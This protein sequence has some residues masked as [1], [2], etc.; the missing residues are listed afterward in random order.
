V[1]IDDLKSGK[2]SL[3]SRR[4]ALV[5]LVSYI[6]GIFLSLV[7]GI[8]YLTPF[9]LSITLLLITFY[10]YTKGNSQFAGWSA[11]ILMACIGWFN[12]GL[13]RG[14][15]PPNHISRIA[16]IGG[17]VELVG[18]VSEEPDIRSD[19]TY[20]V[21][22]I[23]SVHVGGRWIP[24]LGRA[25]VKVNEGGSLYDHADRISARG[26][27]YK[28]RGA[29]NPLGFDYGA[30]LRA[31]NI[32]AGVSVRSSRNVEIIE[33]GHSVLSGII[34]PLREHLLAKTR[35]HLDPVKAAILSGFILGER[36]DIP[37]KYQTMFRNTG[38]LHLMAV[39][40]SN[41]G[42]VL[43]VF[44][45]PLVIMRVPRRARVYVLLPVILF[46]ALLTRM[47]PS[48]VRASI[49]ATVGLMAYGWSRKPDY[50]N[51]LGL[52]GLAMLLWEPAMIFDVGLQL[53]FVATFS[54]V[55]AVRG[56]VML[57]SR[58]KVTD[59]AFVRW[60]MALCLTTV[61]AQIAVMP[62]MARYFN[63]VPVAGVLAN[64]PIGILAA[65][66][67]ALGIAF[68]FLSLL[69]D[70]VSRVASV[71]L[72][73]VLGGVQCCLRF[74][75]AIPHANIR[76]PSPAWPEI[77][78]YWIILYALYEALIKRRLSKTS[79][80]A[81]LAMLNLIVWNGLGRSE[82]TWKLDFVDA[83]RNRIWIFSNAGGETLACYDCFD[84]RYNPNRIVIPHVLNFF[85]GNL[86]Y[87]VTSTPQAPEID[88]LAEQFAPALFSFD[89]PD[90]G[91]SSDKESM[92]EKI[93]LFAKSVPVWAKVVWGKSD[94]KKDM[95][96]PALEFHVEEGVL[97]FSAWRGAHGMLE[98]REN[99]RVILL[100]MPWSAYA[101]STVRKT[102]RD[103]DPGLVVFSPDRHSVSMPN[104]RRELTHSEDSIFSTSI[105]GGFRIYAQDGEVAVKT[106]KA[107]SD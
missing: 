55:Y 101:Q 105:C 60:F 92:E 2:R 56:S 35:E 38:T 12:S 54:I 34:S 59:I 28:P 79:V 96:L 39:S 106:M 52:A 17:L 29:T 88:E 4:P 75:S 1:E 36:R 23:D 61:A 16:R 10:Y 41:V 20:L 18:T 90:G 32:H 6:S 27:L 15:F 24:C 48:V 49:M 100:E 72:D 30:Y 103:L 42:L 11:V 93:S 43:A 95:T 107:V 83:G 8:D 9:A 5:A 57:L 87:L 44:A 25:R 7:T 13:N 94:N 71:P 69:G 98:L 67:T 91:F 76:W 84:N 51:V 70:W 89:L 3:L 47:E 86:D 80:V 82:T 22:D 77:I 85:D 19:R 78:L 102:I 50:I 33:K 73:I 53:S 74:F 104:T 99:R 81:A 68:Y 58:L 31:R 21:V 37:E 26:Y 14:P 64:I 65:I 97:V 45:F 63:N 62:L 40:G 46:F 66:S